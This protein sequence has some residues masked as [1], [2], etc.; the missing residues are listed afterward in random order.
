MNP[1]IFLIAI[2]ALS[3]TT[4]FLMLLSQK[5]YLCIYEPHISFEPLSQFKT[6][7]TTQIISFTLLSISFMIAPLFLWSKGYAYSNEFMFLCG[8]TIT[9]F[10]SYMSRAVTSILIYKYMQ[11]YPELVEGK[12]IFK[13]PFFA[14]M[15]ATI[16]LQHLILVGGISIFIPRTSFILGALFCLAVSILIHYFFRN[17]K[18][19]TQ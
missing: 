18:R 19:A 1:G 11:K 5:L 6:P 17:R 16:S 2:P 15:N 10:L 13:S 4:C 14:V 8:Y 7:I 9:Y 12:T 3:V